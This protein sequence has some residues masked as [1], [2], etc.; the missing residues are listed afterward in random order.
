[1]NDSTYKLV[2]QV[3]GS[4]SCF[5]NNYYENSFVNMYVFFSSVTFIWLIIEGNEIQD[6]DPEL[7]RLLC[8]FTQEAEEEVVQL[9]V[10][11]EALIEESCNSTAGYEFLSKYS[12]K[13]S[14]ISNRCSF[15]SWFF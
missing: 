7:L 15:H 6:S 8:S 14:T 9:L 1:M 2:L 12:P 4:T 11:L 3:K 13:N 5:C 10:Q